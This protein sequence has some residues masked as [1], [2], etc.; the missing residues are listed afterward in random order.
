MHC[1]AFFP[2]FLLLAVLQLVLCPV[3]LMN[4]FLTTVLSAGGLLRGGAGQDRAGQGAIHQSRG[5][6][7]GRWDLTGPTPCRCA[8]AGASNDAPCTSRTQRWHRAAPVYAALWALGLS[9]YFY[10]TFLGY[11]ALPFL[12]RTEVGCWRRVHPKVY[13][14]CLHVCRPGLLSLP[15]RRRLPASCTRSCLPAVRLL[16]A[17]A[18]PF[19]G[20]SGSSL[21]RSPALQLFLYPIALV[22]VMAPLAI[23][24]GVNPTRAALRFWFDYK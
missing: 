20:P 14:C 10:I 19:C 7:G 4:T 16:G 24:A 13:A 15:R 22:A 8:P 5:T 18:K 17:A 21:S 3:L 9:Y 6:A 23:L 1:N 11:S 12:E 2:T